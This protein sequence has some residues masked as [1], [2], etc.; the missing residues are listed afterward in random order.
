MSVV[1]P[2]RTRKGVYKWI[3]KRRIAAAPEWLLELVRK[4]EYA[5]RESD[6][7]T[8][9]ANSIRQTSI[10]ELTLAMAMIPNPDHE[11]NMWNKVGMALYVASDGSAEGY[12]LFDAWSRRSRKYDAQMT[13]DKWKKFGTRTCPPKN[14]TAG[15][16]FFL[17]GAA[18]PEWRERMYHERKVIALIKEFYEL[19]GEPS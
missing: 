2:S 14:I 5:P 4:Q 6:P 15:T 7:F 17:A 18:V 1:P 11:W 10:A 16:I 13:L 19:L 9:F 8:R 12:R 3:N